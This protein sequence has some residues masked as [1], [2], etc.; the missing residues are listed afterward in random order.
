[1]N[2]IVWNHEVHSCLFKKENQE[3]H[4]KTVKMHTKGKIDSKEFVKI[5]ILVLK[6]GMRLIL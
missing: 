2:S 4:L 6:E 1:M 5:W 3:N